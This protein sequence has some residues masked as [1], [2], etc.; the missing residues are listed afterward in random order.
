MDPAFARS[1]DSRVVKRAGDAEPGL[2]HDHRDG[3]QVRGPKPPPID[4]PPV[5]PVAGHDECQSADV[6]HDDGQVRQQHRIGKQSGQ[7][8]GGECGVHLGV[9]GWQSGVT[10]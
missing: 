7:G 3:G 1:H 4:P 2:R 5:Q 10:A 6:E 8:R 9:L